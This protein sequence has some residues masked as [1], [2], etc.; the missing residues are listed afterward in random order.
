MQIPLLLFAVVSLEAILIS[1]VA[2]WFDTVPLWQISLLVAGGF[3]FL[4]W[5]LVRKWLDRHIPPTLSAAA[6]DLQNRVAMLPDLPE[7][8]EGSTASETVLSAN[9]RKII[10]YFTRSI[11]VVGMQA[12]NASALIMELVQ[13]HKFIGKDSQSLFSLAGE[14]D[15]NNNLLAQ[16][17]SSIQ[18]Q[19]SQISM[20]MD[21]LASSSADISGFIEQ[22][23]QASRGA[24]DN[25]QSMA[26]AADAMV[27]HLQSVFEQLH[28]SRD[29]TAVVSTAT[30]RM[31]VSFAEVRAQCFAAND[32]S[33]EANKASRSFGSV[34]NELNAAAKQI[35]TVVDFIREIA[36]MT[37]MLSLNAAIEAAGAGEAG[38]GFA[39]VANEIK[40][41][42]QRTLQATGDIEEKILEIQRKSAEASMVAEKLSTQV[43]HIHAI[44][45]EI[46][47]A[48][49][50]Q[51]EATQHVSCSMDQVKDAMSTIMQRSHKLQSATQDV[52]A[53]S[54]KGVASV[55]EISL[56]AAHVSSIAADM[57][58]QTRDA[59]KFTVSTYAFA[60]KTNDLSQQVKEKLS[61]S[62]RM[63]RF[64]HGSVNH[65]G[66]LSGIA[67]ETND[68]FHETL[69]NFHGFSEPFEM[70]RFKGS[71]MNMMGQLA[72]A[73]F[74]NVKLKQDAFSAWENSE[75]GKWLLLNQHAPGAAGP[76]LREI[77]HACQAMHAAA[78]EVVTCLNDQ[79]PA[80]V[81]EAMRAVNAHRR[82][83]FAALDGLYLTPITTR[84]RHTDLVEWHND[85]NI[86]IAE[87]DTD[88]QTLF[89]M[90][91]T[92][93]NAIHDPEGRGQHREIFRD[94]FRYGRAHFEREERLMEQAADPRLAEHR[95]Q[96]HGF[97]AQADKFTEQM[98][99]ESYT[100][101][102]DMSLF[103][104]N[105][106]A[107][108]IAKWDLEMGRHLASRRRG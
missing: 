92:A 22:V 16:E 32:A 67:R 21:V 6:Q 66:I 64:L 86:G 14:I 63:T 10:Q 44:N 42:A 95:A 70:Y 71:V 85:L 82:T 20:N 99:E 61:T 104:R 23:A 65:F 52:A 29:S 37:G 98:G 80:R 102:L 9:I 107:F 78:T 76:R 5:L 57:E 34:S 36:D 106:F 94:L 43:E 60:K 18:S 30:E 59:R 93:H 68:G 87:V 27:L 89:G 40:T 11:H 15:G 31:V 45:Q 69:S 100:L 108:H 28:R 26:R 8:G 58:E 48:V 19:L 2:S 35:G 12:G 81:E 17:V 77:K 72:K 47:K 75:L 88:H 25:L 74:G 84:F 53:E 51:H 7:T 33:G 79:Q 97:I 101:L 73:A 54:S 49:D 105:W 4:C 24:E 46:A 38:R 83:L 103:V 91:N 41:L 39:V 56:K 90:L 96:H 62:L 1:G 50:D 3:G 55:K 13:V